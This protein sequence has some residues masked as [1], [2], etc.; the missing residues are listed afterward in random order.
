MKLKDA[1]LGKQPLG[2]RTHEKYNNAISAVTVGVDYS[3]SPNVAG[4]PGFIW[5]A[6]HGLHGGYSH[7]Y[8][9]GV[10]N[11]VNVPVVIMQYPKKPYIRQAIQP[12][13]SAAAALEWTNGG[14]VLQGGAP[15][16]DKH[17]W[18]DWTPGFDAVNVY[19]RAIVPLR[20]FPY[21]G[22]N[23]YVEYCRYVHDGEII[24]YP[25]GVFDWSAYSN[26]SLSTTTFVLIYL[27]KATNTVQATYNVIDTS[28]LSEDYTEHFPSLPD[29]AIPSAV[30]MHNSES[31]TVEAMITDVRGLYVWEDTILYGWL[32]SVQG[33]LYDVQS[34]LYDLYNRVWSSP[35]STST[36]EIFMAAASGR[37][38]TTNGCAPAVAIEFPTNDVDEIVMDFDASSAEYAQWGVWM[39]NDWDAGTVT[40]KV[41]WLATSGTPTETVQWYLQGRHYNQQAE[42]D[43]AWGTAVGVSDTLVGTDRYH[44]TDESAI[45]TLAGSPQPGNW[46]KFRLYR[47]PSSDTLSAD[48][49][50]V[51]VK[52]FY[53]RA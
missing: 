13:W 12:D 9:A 49:R 36:A 23:V 5:V 41:N 53:T 34:D 19:T 10:P 42:V 2:E 47:D 48:A 24:L 35:A 31:D 6:E 52:I 28:F 22:L 20:C 14:E 16:H 46:V 33:D 43:A 11:M 25:G 50:L 39:P 38:S 15:H 45:V 40:Y 17:E 4:R 1:L 32:D 30:I 21:T 29:N 18:P 37:P 26:S 7:A 8:N 3:N 27:N 51:A 44:Y